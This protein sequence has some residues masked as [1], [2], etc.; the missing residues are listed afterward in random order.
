MGW[1]NWD[2]DLTKGKRFPSAHNMQT[3]SETTQPSSEWTP[4]VLL[5]GILQLGH[6]TTH[7]H[8]MPRLRKSGALLID[9]T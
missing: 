7:L 9:T 5:L 3:G 1:M 4:S 6:E 2:L 8:L